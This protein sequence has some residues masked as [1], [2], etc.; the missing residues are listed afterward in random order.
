MTP[1]EHVLLVKERLL[2]DP[3]VVRF[4]MHRER[5]TDA[6]GYLRARVELLDGSWLE[7]SEYFERLSDN[8]I[9]VLT[10]SYHWGRA[11]GSLKTRWDNTPHHPSLA[12]FPHHVH[13]GATEEVQ[14]GAGINIF[15][16]LD[17][18]AALLAAHG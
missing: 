7:F 11:D 9:Q 16:V 8:T 5:I 14:P 4:Q 2:N 12:G 3:L 10:Y 13:D 1:A 18:I 15:A 6:S 17:R